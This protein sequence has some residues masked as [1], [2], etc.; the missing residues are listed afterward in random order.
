MVNDYVEATIVEYSAFEVMN[1]KDKENKCE[2]CSIKRIFV[3][4]IVK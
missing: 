1:V 2:I 3:A 4:V